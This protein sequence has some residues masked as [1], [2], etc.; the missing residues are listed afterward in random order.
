MRGV[1]HVGSPSN[2]LFGDRVN[3]DLGGD[4]SDSELVGTREWGVVGFGDAARLRICVCEPMSAVCCGKPE[5][6]TIAHELMASP[7]LIITPGK[8]GRVMTSPQSSEVRMQR[9]LAGS[10]PDCQRRLSEP[11]VCQC[12][13]CIRGRKT[14]D[15][16]IGEAGG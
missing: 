16:E 8:D 13:L 3:A 6:V 9:G 14:D 1:D 15:P 12:A 4:G 11:F 5:L 10:K 2:G 7:C